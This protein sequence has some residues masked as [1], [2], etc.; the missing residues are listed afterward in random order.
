MRH[1][2]DAVRARHA[3]QD[4]T[5]AAPA[6]TPAAQDATPTAQDATPTAQD[7]TPTA[8]DATPAA[9]ASTPAASAS[10]PAAQD[11]TPAAPDATPAAPDEIPGGLLGYLARIRRLFCE[12]GATELMP[13]DRQ[14]LG[15][16]IFAGCDLYVR[17]VARGLIERPDLF[18]VPGVD[19]AQLARRQKRARAWF[20]VHAALT[21]MAGDARDSYLHEQGLAIA[22]ANRVIE[23]VRNEAEARALRGQ[24]GPDERGM[25]QLAALHEALWV[26]DLRAAAKQRARRR[27]AKAVAE[28]K[29][30][31]AQR[32]KKTRDVFTRED[33]ERYKRRHA[34]RVRRGPIR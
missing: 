18:D 30:P 19:G 17:G 3:A 29:R 8:Q 14:R 1:I 11:A 27:A 23:T 16:M 4:A 31:P 21:R 22:D 25:E 13:A 34:E 6:S 32:E 12:M 15:G 9:P 33:Y 7:A 28:A 10:T 20:W 5:P 24:E 2:V 26:M